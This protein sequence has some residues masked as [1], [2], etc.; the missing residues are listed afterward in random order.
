MSFHHVF[1]AEI[2]REHCPDRSWSATDVIRHLQAQPQSAVALVGRTMNDH[3]HYLGVTYDTRLCS[4]HSGHGIHPAG[5]S[6]A[7]MAITGT[8]DADERG[9]MH[10]RLRCRVPPPTLAPAQSSSTDEYRDV[11]DDLTLQIR[12]LKGA[13]KRCRQRGPD[14]FETKAL[15]E[16]KVYNLTTQRKQQLAAMLQDFAASV[17]SCDSSST[18]GLI[19]S[20]SRDMALSPGSNS[21][22]LRQSRNSVRNPT[23][24]T[25]SAYASGSML[26][27]SPQRQLGSSTFAPWARSDLEVTNFLSVAP[28]WPDF[29]RATTSNK[30]RKR[31]VVQ[32]LEELFTGNTGCSHTIHATPAPIPIISCDAVAA[33]ATNSAAEASQDPRI[34]DTAAAEPLREAT[35]LPIQFRAVGLGEE[36]A[37]WDEQ[38]QPMSTSSENGV[39][40]DVNSE[41]VPEQRPTRISDVDPHRSQIPSANIAYIRHLGIEVPDLFVGQLRREPKTYLSS[42]GWIHLSLLYNMAQLHLLSVTLSFVRLAVQEIS[43]K[44]QVSQDGCKLRWLGSGEETKIFD[45]KSDQSAQVENNPEVATKSDLTGCGNTQMVCNP[46]EISVQ[47]AG[48]NR[49]FEY[50]P[51]FRRKCRAK[52]QFELSIHGRNASLD[53]WSTGNKNRGRASSTP[54]CYRKRRRTGLIIYYRNAPFCVDLQGDH[55][56]T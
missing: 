30:K 35:V 23:P 3:H 42:D 29:R 49:R 45:D 14:V 22:S 20:S 43:T 10:E 55:G 21:A 41:T 37:W 50:T 4:L 12:Q 5:F 26:A 8:I 39:H 2:F 34:Y 15:F 16:L 28:N 24:L 32:R 53:V 44:F 51:L 25:D 27:D 47:P 13:L 19:N 9:T 56:E 7:Y 31:M 54:S 36:S 48:S 40:G 17:G 52:E 18:L 46:V 11:I 1:G 38:T 6:N 33:D